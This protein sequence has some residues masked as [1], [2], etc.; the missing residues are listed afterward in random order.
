MPQLDVPGR[1]AARRLGWGR[2]INLGDVR[3]L[4]AFDKTLDA[5]QRG[6]ERVSELGVRRLPNDHQQSDA[7]LHDRGALVWLGSDLPIVG[8]RYPPA[9]AGRLE[10]G[11][12]ACVRREVIM[13][14]FDS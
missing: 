8:Q 14:S 4:V 5:R 1:L 7:M 10:P 6:H 11:F 3:R 2:P 9:L 13:V 12:V